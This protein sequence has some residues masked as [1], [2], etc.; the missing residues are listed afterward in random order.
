MSSGQLII[1]LLPSKY[2]TEDLIVISVA[3]GPLCFPAWALILL[4][5]GHSIFVG[6]LTI[7]LFLDSII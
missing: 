1:R 7:F 6:D 2:P 3:V 4:A 5:G